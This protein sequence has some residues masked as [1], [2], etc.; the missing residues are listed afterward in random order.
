MRTLLI[1]SLLAVIAFSI[2]TRRGIIEGKKNK[3]KRKQNAKK[4]VKGMSK[5]DKKE[6]F[7]QWGVSGAKGYAAA[8]EDKYQLEK[9]LEKQKRFLKKRTDRFKSAFWASFQKY[10]KDGEL[11]FDGQGNMDSAGTYGQYQNGGGKDLANF[12]GS[13]LDLPWYEI[14]YNAV[15]GR[16][17]NK[18]QKRDKRDKK[19]NDWFGIKA[20]SRSMDKMSKTNQSGGSDYVSQD[21]LG[22]YVSQTDLDGYNYLKTSEF[23]NTLVNDD[24]FYKLFILGQN[25]SGVDDWLK[26]P[27][28]ETADEQAARR[29]GKIEDQYGKHIRF[30]S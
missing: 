10:Y 18:K 22:A 23:S 13:T 11:K 8:R 29:R 12:R 15:E 4:A 17:R 2:S 25:E 19:D 24:S 28:D 6:R 7:K 27:D 26:N 30:F 20:V 9:E 21:A 16:A 1:L 14:I 5:D 3:K